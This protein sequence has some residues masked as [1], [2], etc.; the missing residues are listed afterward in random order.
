MLGN[1]WS[2]E[3]LQQSRIIII[4]GTEIDLGS[5]VGSY[6]YSYVE[7]CAGIYNRDAPFLQTAVRC[8]TPRLPSWYTMYYFCN[9]HF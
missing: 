6:I 5:H 4:I 1:L 7:N 3:I 9:N 8:Q 2:H